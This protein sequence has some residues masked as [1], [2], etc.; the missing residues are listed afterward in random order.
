[1]TISQTK[2][3]PWQK[4]SRKDVKKLSDN[5]IN[6]KY[7][8]GERR[9]LLEINREKLPSFADSL[10]KPNYMEKRPFYQRRD[11]WDAQKQSR[12]IESFLMN[13]PVP[14][15]ILY[16]T[17]YNSYEVMDGQQ[18]ITAIDNFYNNKLE[19]TG[20]EIWPELEG[21]TYESLPAKI[22]DGIN[23]R[24]ISTIVVITESLSDIEEALSLK[25]LVFERLNTGGV[26]LSRQEIRNC[27]YSGK[28]N[29]L[30]LKLSENNIF[31]K[32]W[33]IPIYNQEK[34]K[35]NRFYEKMGDVELILRFFALRDIDQYTGNLS[36]YLDNYMMKKSLNFSD[37]NIQEFEQVFNQTIE[38]VSNIYQ[39]QLFK[40]FDSKTKT[41]KSKAYKV[42]YDAVMISF[43]NHL[44]DYQ[45]LITRK[46]AII[47]ET[48]S[49]FTQD[50]QGITHQDKKLK[51]GLFTGE[52]DTK[53]DI[54][55]RIQIFDS[56]IQRVLKQS[57]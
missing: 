13:I 9:I 18:R 43:S 19:L 51:K 5:E 11:R 27:I 6:E 16:E 38:L 46:S 53:D 14:P 26:G 55:A 56:L 28:F 8:Q 12:L 7:E 35:K 39:D 20:L 23:R 24:A 2:T 32:A 25:Q 21:R 47:D 50:S 31:A 29:Q 52:G 4:R 3:N 48:I 22:K 1:M 42:Y 44:S 54:K 45:E 37:E 40:P 30:L 57:I 17:S 33:N 34:L 15:L 36:K 41:H 49:L 10:K